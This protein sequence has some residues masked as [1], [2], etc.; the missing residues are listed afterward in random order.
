MALRW[1]SI[2]VRERCFRS[3]NASSPMPAIRDREWRK[4]LRIRAA[5]LSRS[6]NVTSCTSLSFCQTLDRRTNVGMDQPQSSLGARLRALCQDRGR[7]RSLGDDP[8]HAPP[9]N[10][11]KPL[12]MNPN[13][14]DGLSDGV[15]ESRRRARQHPPQLLRLSIQ[16]VMEVVS[17]AGRMPRYGRSRM[18][19]R[20]GRR[21]P[22]RH[23]PAWCPGRCTTRAAT[24]PRRNRTASRPLGIPSGRSVGGRDLS[25]GSVLCPASSK[26]AIVPVGR[27]SRTK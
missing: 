7:L 6:S 26:P 16:A 2:L 21:T 19:A 4:P 9:L 3:L 24:L 22:V 23:A 20:S 14:L 25:Q 11:A 10:T 15:S 18:A 27:T 17:D 12:R 1:F 13:F 8:H 5:G